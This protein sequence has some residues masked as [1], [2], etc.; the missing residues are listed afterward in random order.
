MMKKKFIIL[1]TVILILTAQIFVY[2]DE[3]KVDNTQKVVRI[4]DIDGKEWRI[5]Y[6]IYGA[7]SSAKYSVHNIAEYVGDEPY[8]R[9]GKYGYYA[10]YLTKKNEKRY[11]IMN[12]QGYDLEDVWYTSKIPS[13]K[14]FQKYVKTG[15]TLDIIKL[16]DSDAY[17]VYDSFGSGNSKYESFHRFADGT[18]ARVNYKKNS[19]GKWIVDKVWYLADEM[20]VVENLI[21][22]DFELIK[23]DNPNEEKEFLKKLKKIEGNYSQKIRLKRG[24]IKTIKRTGKNIIII[25]LKKI[26]N[27]KKYQIQYA[28][29][30]KFKKAKTKVT[31]K[32]K[33]KIKECKINRFY[34][35]RVRGIN[36]TVK[37]AWSKI[38]KV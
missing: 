32:I 18:M 20:H 9:M 19:K 28:T 29:N 14:L 31:K 30:K 35:I 1:F 25:K 3:F 12:F 5:P 21:S 36:G 27:A 7:L 23:N 16:I 22:I 10:V 17:N 34:Y 24:K 2:A 8:W 11:L 15:T 4:S 6:Y 13:K 38:R 26:K 37:G 33:Y